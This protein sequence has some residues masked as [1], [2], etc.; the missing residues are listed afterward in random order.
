MKACPDGS[1][2]GALDFSFDS[3]RVSRQW[4]RNRARRH[5]LPCYRCGPGVP[6]GTPR[7]SPVNWRTAAQPHC[8]RPSRKRPG[9]QLHAA[10]SVACTDERL[11]L[12]TALKF[13]R[14]Q[15]CNMTRED[16]LNIKK[17]QPGLQT[18]S[19]LFL[20]LIGRADKLRSHGLPNL[21]A[22]QEPF[23][24]GSHELVHAIRANRRAGAKPAC[25][26]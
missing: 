8:A 25:R 16:A 20:R 19:P 13:G 10:G 24:G 12:R 11:G 23:P 7:R 4:R 5:P 9:R 1:P 2:V 14:Y 22:C 3:D 6:P 18:G 26:T 17:R 21:A 15:L